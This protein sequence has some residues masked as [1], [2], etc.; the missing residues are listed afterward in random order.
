MGFLKDAVGIARSAGLVF[1]ARSG[2]ILAGALAFSTLLSVVPLLLIALRVASLL[3]DSDVARAALIENMGRWVGPSLAAEV[4]DWVSAAQRSGGGVGIVGA[5]VLAYASTRL[6]ATL[7]RAFDILWGIDPMATS[8]WKERAERFLTKRLFAF[9]LVLSVGL[10]LVALVFGHTMLSAVRDFSPAGLSPMGPALEYAL[11][12]VL[13]VA[14]FSVLFLVLPNK[15]IPVKTAATGGVV[16]ATLFTLGA[17]LVGTYV[18]HKA[19]ESTF[20]AATSLVL[21]LLW[22]HYAAH[23]FFYGAAITVVLTERRPVRR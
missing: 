12:F 1:A 7:T 2:R 6:F 19:G 5:A 3:I 17:V 4:S 15:R 21:L 16:T 8:T 18:G 22:V 10:L 11:S 20:G 23:A 14:L 9:G 13:T